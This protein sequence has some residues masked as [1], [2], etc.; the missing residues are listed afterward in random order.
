M[1]AKS[2]PKLKKIT[3]IVT[4][5]LAVLI[6]IA[7]VFFV[8]SK[9]SNGIIYIGNKSCVFVVSQSMEPL[10]ETG[11]FIVVEKVDPNDIKVD[12][13]I[14]F[15]SDDPEIKD[16]FNT[17]KV[18]EIIGDNDE[19]VT[20]GINN[21]RNDIYTAKS[22]NVYGR[23]VKNATLLNRFTKW[24]TTPLGL[25]ITIIIIIAVCLMTYLPGIIKAFKEDKISEIDRDFLIKQE[26]ERLRLE[27]DERKKQ[28]EESKEI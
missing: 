3:G 22:E 6:V 9:C 19:F 25:L 5:V 14:I 15:K 10:I 4:S 1:M 23:Y 11:S 21:P 27:D 24:F 28:S 16:S 12:D 13:I 26:I 18:V 17:H 2:N 7:S 20:R 8:V